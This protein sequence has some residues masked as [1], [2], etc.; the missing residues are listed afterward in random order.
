MNR[1]L[2][3][4]LL[5]IVLL[6]GVATLWRSSHLAEREAHIPPPTPLVAAQKAS[7]PPPPPAATPATGIEDIH[8]QITAADPETNRARLRQLRA[9]LDALPRAV[10]SR[11]V[12]AFLA[13]GRDT[14]T[15]LDLTV[16]SGGRLGDSSSLRVFLLDYLGQ[17][18]RSA[19]AIIGRAILAAPTSPDEWAVSM[20]NVAW[21]D[22]APATRGYLLGKAREMISHPAWRENPSAGFLEAFDV[23]VHTRGYELTPKLTDFLRDK[24]QRGLAHAAYLTLDRLTLADPAAALTLLAEQPDLMAGREQT[25]ANFFARLDV[26]DGAQKTVLERY[27]LDPRRTPQELRTFAGIF[28]NANYMVSQNL[29]TSNHTAPHSDLRAHDRAAL[30]V[31]DAWRA[32]PRFTKLQPHLEALRIRLAAFVA[33]AATP[34]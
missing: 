10:A 17:I 3:Y 23:I 6:G 18:D 14:L 19:A 13:L 15:Q 22:D 25:R 9:L 20:R 21:A 1:K 7:P 33:Q 11:E 5:L 16:Q 24:E 28:P 27:L 2:S 30:G 29:L 4:C 12:Q 34:P 26:R 31:I 8:G 32:D